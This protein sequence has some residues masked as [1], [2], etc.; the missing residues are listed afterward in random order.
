MNLS[1]R[2]RGRKR[3]LVVLKSER[4]QDGA[5]FRVSIED[6]CCCNQDSE[7]NRMP[8]VPPSSINDADS[9]KRLMKTLS[10]LRFCQIVARLPRFK[11]DINETTLRP[12]GKVSLVSREFRFTNNY[13]QPLYITIL[14]LSAAYGMKQLFPGQ[15]APS[16]PI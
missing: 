2:R 9:I 4:A 5:A 11:C 14:N 6:S 12:D 10:H 8:N 7:G 3:L 1:Q 15:D 16:E 13:T